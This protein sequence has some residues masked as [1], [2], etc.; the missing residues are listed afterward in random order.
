[1]N[2]VVLKAALVRYYAGL[3]RE[4]VERRPL[5]DRRSGTMCGGG[6]IGR[7]YYFASRR[8]SSGGCSDTCLIP[9]SRTTITTVQS[10]YL[11]SL[12]NWRGRYVEYRSGGRCRTERQQDPLRVALDVFYRADR[13]PA[14]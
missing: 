12:Y 5:G 9:V 7:Q 1:M 8:Y 4:R 2:S 11:A 3:A 10:I 14:P 6:I 13:Q